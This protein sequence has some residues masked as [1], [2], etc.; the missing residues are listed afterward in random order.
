MVHLIIRVPLKNILSHVFAN[1]FVCPTRDAVLQNQRNK[2]ENVYP[3]APR[4][5]L[6]CCGHTCLGY[7][8]MALAHQH[9]AARL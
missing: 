1:H 8:A 7:P 5:L 3:L 9:S 4:D 2:L 6:V